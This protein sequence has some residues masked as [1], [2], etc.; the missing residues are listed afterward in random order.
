[1]ENGE[2]TMG[3]ITRREML[4]RSSLLMAALGGGLPLVAAG[5]ETAQAARKLK[6]VVTG[7]HPDDPESGCG[8]TIARYADEGHEVVI[9]Y[10]T[11]GESGI[12]GTS[13]QEAAR[14]RTAEVEKACAIL[15][16]RPVFAGQIDGF[17]EVNQT[18]YDEFRKLLEAEKPDIVFT[19]W[20]VDTHRDHR[21]ASLLTYDAWLE[22]GRKFDL[23]YYEVDLGKQT[24]IFHPTDYVD[25]STTVERKK[26]ACFEHASQQPGPGFWILHDAMNHFR[27][28]EG[29]VPVAEGFV[30]QSQNLETDV[31]KNRD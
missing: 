16:A 29:G 3:D 15:K 8:G 6:V 20:P 9:L 13:L 14:I 22:G 5:A 2:D 28:M 23:Y 17:T 26:A 21:A 11:R 4:G 10:L 1:M 27:G 24:Q 30:R 25:I 7:G 12:K 31:P 19:H 18:R